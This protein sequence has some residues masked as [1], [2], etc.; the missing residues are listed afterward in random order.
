MEWKSQTLEHQIHMDNDI[1]LKAILHRFSNFQCS[2][3]GFFKNI[4]LGLQ[5]QDVVCR[6]EALEVKSNNQ[7]VF[8]TANTNNMEE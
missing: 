8:Y 4:V 5:M 6:D 7:H 2:K 3:Y 1:A